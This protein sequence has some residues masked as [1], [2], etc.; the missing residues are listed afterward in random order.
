MLMQYPWQLIFIFKLH[1]VQLLSSG[2]TNIVQIQF[3]RINLKCYLTWLSVISVQV[4][5]R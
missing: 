2:F 1:Q 5:Q 3:L 4:G